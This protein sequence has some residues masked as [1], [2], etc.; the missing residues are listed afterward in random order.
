[1]I[2]EISKPLGVKLILEQR[3]FDRELH[4]VKSLGRGFACI[5]WD[6]DELDLKN[7]KV[8]G[9]KVHSKTLDLVTTLQ[10]RD[11]NTYFISWPGHSLDIELM[12]TWLM[13]LS[14]KDKDNFLEDHFSLLIS[15]LEVFDDEREVFKQVA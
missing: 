4:E 11:D 1:M 7:I 12:S 8:L 3:G 2:K 14:K 9:L 13:G 6:K 5:Q 15:S 10:R